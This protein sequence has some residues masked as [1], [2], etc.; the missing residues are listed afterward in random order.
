MAE[1][2]TIDYHS[3]KFEVLENSVHYIHIPKCM[4]TPCGQVTPVCD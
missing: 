1:I 2:N 3:V 4:L